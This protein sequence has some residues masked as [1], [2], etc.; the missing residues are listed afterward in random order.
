[1]YLEWMFATG[2][3]LLANALLSATSKM[4]LTL[5]RALDPFIQ[6][7]WI[8]EIL[9]SGR[10]LL[11][12]CAF[13]R[14]RRVVIAGRHALLR[15]LLFSTA[16]LEVVIGMHFI[17]SFSLLKLIFLFSLFTILAAIRIPID[18]SAWKSS[19]TPIQSVAEEGSAFWNICFLH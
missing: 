16:R 12:T 8:Y 17:W 2:L 4:I 19:R 18:F 3:T 10:S 11:N 7:G 9:G 1:M 14:E 13:R 6:I 5:R 15:D